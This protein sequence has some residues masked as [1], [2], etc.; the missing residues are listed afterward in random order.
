VLIFNLN[1]F[2]LFTLFVDVGCF[3]GGTTVWGLVC[4]GGSAIRASACLQLATDHNMKHISLSSDADVVVNSLN[5]KCCIAAIDSF[6]LDCKMLME[7]FE[8]VFVYYVRRSS[9]V[10]AHK[11]V[12]LSRRIGSKAVLLHVSR[13]CC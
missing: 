7:Q 2:S 13:L 10:I 8:F 6:S 11:L 3:V 4:L 1:K 9:N 5:I 12:G